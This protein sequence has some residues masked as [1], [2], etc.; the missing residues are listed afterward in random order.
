MKDKNG[1]TMSVGD[2]VQ[3]SKGV[4]RRLGLS[5]NQGV[6]TDMP[7]GNSDSPGVRIDNS[8]YICTILT[9]NLTVI[10]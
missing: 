3:I 9:K 8:S 6:I 5:T 4:C 10:K 7:L 2:R 1:N